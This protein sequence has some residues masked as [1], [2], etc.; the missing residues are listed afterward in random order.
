M[1]LTPTPL[2]EQTAK[3]AKVSSKKDVAQDITANFRTAASGMYESHMH[4][5]NID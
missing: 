5:Q 2:F 1:N 4:P 3:G